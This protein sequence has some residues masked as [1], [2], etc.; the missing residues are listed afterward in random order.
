MSQPIRIAMWIFALLLA[1]YFL[2]L[3]LLWSQQERLIYPAPRMAGP[4]TGGFEEITYRTEDGLDL[5]AGYRA[6]DVGKPTIVYFHGNG[7]DWVSSVVATERLVPAGYGVLAAEY[8][9]YRGNPG[10]PSEQGLYRDGRAALRFLAAQG[11]AQSEIVMIGNSIGSGVATQLATESPP[12]ALVLI[13]PFA[14]LRQ[15]V[16]EKMRLF[17]TDRLLRHRYE[18]AEKISAVKAP[19]LVLHGDADTLI[20]HHHSRQL[21]RSRPDAELIIYPGK[22][23][24]LAWHDEAEEAVLAFLQNLPTES[25]AS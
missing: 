12:R 6:A 5:A 22:G 9:G 1:A 21:V 2:V 14:S 10:I 7:A 17:P 19:L 20:P 4:T 3:L 11:V 25:D 13:S 18:N 15:L 8:R 23:H 16:G 24:D